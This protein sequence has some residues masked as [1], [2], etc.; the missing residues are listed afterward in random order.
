MAIIQNPDT[1]YEQALALRYWVRFDEGE[2]SFDLDADKLVGLYA[3][4]LASALDNVEWP[5]IIN[6]NSREDYR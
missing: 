5:E 2:D 4:L 3:D 1:P 6:T